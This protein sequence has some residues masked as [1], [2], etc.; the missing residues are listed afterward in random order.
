VKRHLLTAASVATAALFAGSVSAQT[1]LVPNVPLVLPVT[2]SSANTVTTAG[3]GIIDVASDA[4]YS[5]TNTVSGAGSVSH[6]GA[7]N[8]ILGGANTYTNLG[9]NRGTVTLGSNTA[10][11]ISNIAINNN[12]T[13][14]AG[15]NNLVVANAVQTT[16]NGL[17]NAGAA[18]NTLTLG[19][20][21][22]GAGSISQVGQ[23]NLVLNGNNSFNNLGI[24]RG[25]VTLGSN[26]AGGRGGISINNNATLAA[27]V[28]GLVVANAIQ[29]TGA[30]TIDSGT[31]TFTLSGN[32]GNVGSITK[33]GTGTLILTGNNT[34]SGGTT[35]SA[36]TLL[37]NGNNGAS[38]VT[39]ASGGTLGGTGRVATTNVASGGT[40]APGNN[41]VGT[42]V[43]NGN[44]TQAAGSIY[45]V[46]LG[47]PNTSDRIVIGGGATLASGA[48]LNV[49][50]A[51]SVPPALGA[52]Y[53]VLSTGAL[54]LTGTYTLTNN[55]ISQFIDA[56]AS[57]DQRNVYLTVAQTRSFVS[58][59]DT[60]NQAA[61]AFGVE[62]VANGSLYQAIAYL[63]DAASAQNAF[64]QISGEL[65]ATLQTETFEDSRFVREAIYSHTADQ[66]MPGTGLW[67][68]GFGSWG[69]NGGDGNA[70]GYDR[71]IGGFFL[72][73]DAVKTDNLSV[74]V[75]TGYSTANI[76][77]ADRNSFASTDDLHVGLYG[78]YDVAGFSLSAGLSNTF[79]WVG[80]RR[81]IS[82]QG[83]Q[84]TAQANYSINTFQAFG[85]AAYQFRF[86]G[87]GIEPY[88]NFTYLSISPTTFTESGGP[89][90]L[91]TF[92]DNGDDYWMTHLG[93]RAS[94]GLPVFGD[95]YSLTA[96][97]GWRYVFEGDM[98]SPTNMRFTQAG[99]GYTVFGAPIAQ[100]A[101]ATSFSI[102]KKL[103]DRA[104]IDIGYSGQY[105]DGWN[106]SGVRAALR[107]RF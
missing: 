61:A 78:S 6:V 7:G 53:T 85:E 34:H 31:G 26:T 2:G 29:T 33:T 12:A 44:Y 89:A 77:I 92:D 64:D 63:P 58:A 90:S 21:I 79:R 46:Q 87:V 8:L 55:R 16:A 47:A 96:S 51:M 45:N 3:N 86:S 70:A 81:Q 75:V 35:V 20:N 98:L 105:G 82:F 30:G 104:D 69:S 42:L 71:S 100:N 62:R 4:N 50:N 24:N 9:I 65:H 107:L 97:A 56:V 95:T 15:A 49:S 76:T 74:G 72:G 41:G 17:V 14:A 13:L 23:G 19:G 25:T 1:V 32:I 102:S 37:V 27:G 40:V 28:S 39:V 48:I 52:R 67:V 43:V 66:F 38:V 60:A 91:S 54:G 59:A 68:A 80:T 11:G 88:A 57:Y 73:L 18:G 10:G 22:T 5:F 103:D 94:Y 101:I 83:F 106:D 93:L 84:E 36:G 99:P